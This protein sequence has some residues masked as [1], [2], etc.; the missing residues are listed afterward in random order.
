VPAAARDRLA[1]FGA[2]VGR[3]ELEQAV[4]TLEARGDLSAAQRRIVADLVAGI[5]DGVLAPPTATLAAA[6]GDGEAAP[7][8]DAEAGVGAG[9]L[10]RTA[11]YL[12]DL[13]EQCHTG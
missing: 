7:A 11:V 8:G 13:S 4:T 2:A 5:V 9:R 6:E 10:A 12:F 3:R 1:R